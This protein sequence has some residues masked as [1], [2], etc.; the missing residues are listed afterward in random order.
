MHLP[1]RRPKPAARSGR[2]TS[3]PRVAWR[4]G[5][6]VRHVGHRHR[7]HRNPGSTALQECD[8]KLPL[9]VACWDYD[10]TRALFDGRVQIEGCNTNYLSLPVEETFFR[11]LR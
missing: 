2:T 10:R 9:T 7:K 8:M 1:R 5:G 3:A 11:A 4:R 6:P